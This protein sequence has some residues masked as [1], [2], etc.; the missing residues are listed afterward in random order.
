MKCTSAW[1]Q[2][3][4]EDCKIVVTNLNFEVVLILGTKC[5]DEVV[6]TLGVEKTGCNVVVV[7]NT[8]WSQGG[9]LLFKSLAFM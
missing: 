3:V 5:I 9:V 2:E 4:G 8:R 7:S 1:W 6:E